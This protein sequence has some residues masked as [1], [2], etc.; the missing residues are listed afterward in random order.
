MDARVAREVQQFVARKI[1]G[2]NAVQDLLIGGV[3]RL[4]GAP[5]L[6][7][8]R[9]DRR[10][11]DDVEAVEPA[12]AVESGID[13]RRVDDQHVLEQHAQPGG[14]GMAPVGPFQKGARRLDARRGGGRVPG[15]IAQVDRKCGRRDLVL[16]RLD[17]G[18]Q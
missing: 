17:D 15:G 5:V 3:R 14:E 11:V 18:A 4:G 2:G 7:D 9:G 6:A 13:R 1:G 16:A 12:C 10:P 8:E